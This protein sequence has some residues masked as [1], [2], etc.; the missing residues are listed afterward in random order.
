MKRVDGRIFLAARELEQVAR[1]PHS[2]NY[3]DRINVVAGC[4]RCRALSALGRLLLRRAFRGCQQPTPAALLGELVKIYA[5][6]GEPY[7]ASAKD[8]LLAND[9][10]TWCRGVREQISLVDIPAET[11]HGLFTVTNRIDAVLYD[12][13]E[14][15]VVQF[16]CDKPHPSRCHAEQVMNY[17]ALHARLWTREKYEIDGSNLL[18]VRPSDHGVR[19]E[20]FDQDI[21]TPVLRR[22]IEHILSNVC[23]PDRDGDAFAAKLAALPAIYGDHCWSC[24][25]CFR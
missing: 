4:K 16:L 25:A 20:R 12:V 14:F 6:M 13:D 24:M 18:V 21:P 5:E 11:H 8:A 2:I 15:A 10:M 19:L 7:Q 9:L 17:R 23:A 3:L 1:C 22:S